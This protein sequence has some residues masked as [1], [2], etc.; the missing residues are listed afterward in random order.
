MSA[1]RQVIP[2]V[3]VMSTRRTTRRHFLLRPDADGVSQ[4]IFLYC[5]AWAARKFGI[6]V[7]AVV[8]MSTH[9]HVILTDPQG[10]LPRFHEEFHRHL[11]N[12]MKNHRGWP[13]ELLDKR[14]TSV[15]ELLCPAAILDK[16]A[17]A[18]ANPVDCGAVPSARQ[19]PGVIVMPDE[20]GNKTFHAT[21]PEVYFDPKSP[22]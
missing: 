3:S 11:A 2:N 12:A 8:V 4:N 18:I 17:Y 6:Q 21:R 5:L 9:W 1:P 10:V 19:W 7:H 22:L 14:Q 13:A 16:I 20:V 15:V